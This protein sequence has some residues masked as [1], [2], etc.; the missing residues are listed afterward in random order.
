MKT[1]KQVYDLANKLGVDSYYDDSGRS[2]E[3][4]FDSSR[5]FQASGCHCVVVC[6]NKG[7]P[8]GEFWQEAYNDLIAG[9]DDC[10]DSDCDWYLCNG[11]GNGNN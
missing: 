6:F 8:K 9:M 3:I 11:D 1:K 2:Y 5:W 7:G 4:Q 10:D